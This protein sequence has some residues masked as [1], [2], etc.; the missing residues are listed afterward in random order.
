MIIIKVFYSFLF[1]AG[2]FDTPNNTNETISML[3][4]IP[5]YSVAMLV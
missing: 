5:T 1:T 4:Y 3:L 2:Y